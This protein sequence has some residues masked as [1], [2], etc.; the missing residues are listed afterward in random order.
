MIR[1]KYQRDRGKTHIDRASSRRSEM[2]PANETADETSCDTVN[3]KQCGKWVIES[4]QIDKHEQDASPME[5]RPGENRLM[6]CNG[7]KTIP[8]ASQEVQ[9][10][11]VSREQGVTRRFLCHYSCGCCCSSFLAQLYFFWNF[12]TRPALST[13]FIFP[14]KNG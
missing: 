13:Y 3:E 8:S 9:P 12:S 4:L 10:C 5:R 14:V 1:F 2:N 7:T 11:C 6:Q